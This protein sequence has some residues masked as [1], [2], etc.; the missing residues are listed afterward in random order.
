MNGHY[1]GFEE[2]TEDVG[3]DDSMRTVGTEVRPDFCPQ[4]LVGTFNALGTGLNLLKGAR[5]IIWK[6]NSKPMDE[7]QALGRAHRVHQKDTLV[8][9]KFACCGPGGVSSKDNAKVFNSLR[10]MFVETG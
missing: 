4:V 5:M 10:A 2:K 7:E 8:V 9:W 3:E 6:P 1:K